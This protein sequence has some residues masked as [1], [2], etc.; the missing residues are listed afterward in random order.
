MRSELKTSL[1]ELGMKSSTF[2][3]EFDKLEQI[4]VNGQD[5]VKF[6]FSANAGQ[7]ARSLAKTASGENLADYAGH[8]KY[9]CS[10][11]SLFN[12]SF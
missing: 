1:K 4:G 8:Q 6:N 7:Q 11:R 3:V 12:P 9:I 5:D 10:R 2:E